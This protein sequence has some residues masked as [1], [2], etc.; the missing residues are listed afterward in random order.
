[1][2]APHLERDRHRPDGA[3]AEARRLAHEVVQ[4][5]VADAE[6][7][8]EA[9]PREDATRQMSRSLTHTHSESCGSLNQQH[10]HKMQ[11]VAGL[12][13]S[14]TVVLNL[15]MKL[16]TCDARNEVVQ[17]GAQVVQPG[18]HHGSC[19]V[20]VDALQRLGVTAAWHEAAE[21]RRVVGGGRKEGGRPHRKPSSRRASSTPSNAIDVACVASTATAN[22]SSARA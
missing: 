6:R 7:R 19:C 15:R 18:A 10:S 17:L 20:G 11:H 4:R 1:M 8:V 21:R 22:G 13:D 12:C 9:A 5:A 14:S 3:H 16:V 2:P